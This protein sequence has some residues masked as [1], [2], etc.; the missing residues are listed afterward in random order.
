MKRG[1]PTCPRCEHARVHAWWGYLP[2]TRT[3]GTHCSTCHRDWTG[4][5]EAHCTVCHEHF[6]TDG[7]AKAHW[8]KDGH[9]APESVAVL[10]PQLTRFGITW[11]R[12]GE[13]PPVVLASRPSRANMAP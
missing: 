13:L 9:V 7:V 3:V 10:T 4:L 11:R 12:R 1:T 6:S 2:G 5:S 8:T